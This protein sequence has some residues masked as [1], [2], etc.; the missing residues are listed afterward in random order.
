MLFCILQRAPAARR[1]PALACQSTHGGAKLPHLQAA[2][3]QAGCAAHAVGRPGAHA[4]HHRQ[5]GQE[6]VCK[7]HRWALCILGPVV[8]KL[9][10][11]PPPNVA[12][13]Q[14]CIC[15]C[16]RVCYML[17]LL[18][19]HPPTHP[20]DHSPPLCSRVR[21]AHLCGPL[22]RPGAPT[23]QI[24]EQAALAAF[25]T[26]AGVA[27]VGGAGAWGWGAGTAFGPGRLPSHRGLGMGCLLAT[28]S[29]PTHPGRS[30]LPACSAADARLACFPPPCCSHLGNN[31]VLDEGGWQ[32]LVP[33]LPVSVDRRAAGT[34]PS[35][36][37]SCISCQ[38]LSMRAVIV[39]SSPCLSPRLLCRRHLPAHAGKCGDELPQLHMS[40]ARRA[41][42]TAARQQLVM[43]SSVQAT[44]L[45][46]HLPCNP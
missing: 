40:G 7:H 10:A 14:G 5:H 31:S 18:P 23:L 6:R 44:G 42:S 9:A 11:T 20:P 43:H 13:S 22:P 21:R 45:P 33:F 4:A 26:A 36:Q 46:P 16:L 15:M 3:R 27:Q 41:R 1:S 25:Q 38:Q 12:V 24:Q 28:I 34:L 35:Q 32:R 8:H 37:R 30:W 17:R 29:C 39:T 19:A 2:P